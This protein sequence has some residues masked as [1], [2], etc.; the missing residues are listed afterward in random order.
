MVIAF[1][2]AAISS[3]LFGLSNICYKMGIDP[4][5]QLEASKLL[6]LGYIAEIIGSKWIIAGVLLTFGSGVFYLT[7]LSYGDVIE[8]VAVLSLSYLV[9]AVLAN[10]LLNE[11]LTIYKMA[12][13]ALILFGIFLVHVRA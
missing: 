5:G 6:N 7:A 12:G 11:S 9:T 8:V 13:F 10:W 2:L 3:L 4:F 1:S